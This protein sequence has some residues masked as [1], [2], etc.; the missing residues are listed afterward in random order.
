M[1]W[2]HRI[3]REEDADGYCY[4]VHECHYTN[5]AD[6]V[7]TSW[8]PATTVSAETRNELFWILA[9]MMAAVSQPV[10]EIRDNKLFE[11]EPKLELSSEV[12]QAIVKI[13]ADYTVRDPHHA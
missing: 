6:T 4:T 3:I 1:S 2:N 10:L 13:S 11:V 8:S 5:K 7:P 9:H 12:K